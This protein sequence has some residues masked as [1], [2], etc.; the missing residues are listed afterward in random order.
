M[1]LK[2][3]KVFKNVHKVFRW[4][5]RCIKVCG[6][7]CSLPHELIAPGWPK[8]TLLSSS[9]LSIIGFGIGFIAVLSSSLHS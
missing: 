3:Y 7:Y 1:C 4:T 5:C 2:V 9:T 6:H 8:I